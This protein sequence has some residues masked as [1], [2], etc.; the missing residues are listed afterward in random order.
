MKTGHKSTEEHTK[1]NLDLLSIFSLPLK[2]N[3][4][5]NLV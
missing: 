2:G 1:R 5:D 3:S 4:T